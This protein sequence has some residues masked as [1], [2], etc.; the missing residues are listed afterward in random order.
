MGPI[1][2]IVVLVGVFF[3]MWRSSKKQERE[4][5]NMRNSLEVGDEITTIGGIIGEIIKIKEETVTIE[6]GKDR[7]KIRILR[8]A[9]RSV[10]VHAAEKNGTVK[11]TVE[12]PVE[13]APALETAPVV[14]AGANGKKKRSK[15]KKAIEA[16]VEENA[17]IEATESTEN[18]VE[19]VNSTEEV[20]EEA[21]EIVS[22]EST[23]EEAV[24]VEAVEATSEEK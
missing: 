3:L 14:D 19:A 10:D 23:T 22:N 17:V 4:Q 6:T 21:T 5:Q 24:E 8:S 7:T 2:M 15:K 12:A 16:P 1:I 20:T 18:V 9:I 11:K 13:E